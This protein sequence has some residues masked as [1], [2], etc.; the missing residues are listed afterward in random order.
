M[1]EKNY[2]EKVSEYCIQALPKSKQSSSKRKFRFGSL[3]NN[4]HLER[5]N[6]SP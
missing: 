1:G 2:L 5:L 6:K 3:Y 4:F